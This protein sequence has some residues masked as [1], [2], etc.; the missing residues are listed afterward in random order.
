MQILDGKA[1]AEYFRSKISEKVKRICEL[2]FAPPRLAAFLIG[3]NKSSA[4]YIKMKEKACN[5]VGILTR[6]H[7]L[8]ADTP[9][10]KIIELIKTENADAQTSGI[11]VQVPL[12]KHYNEKKILSFID[13]QKDADCFLAENIGQMLIGNEKTV[14]PCTPLGI[15]KLLKYYGIDVA[16]KEVCIIGRSNIVG[17]PLI[18]L[19]LQQNATV[20]ICHSKTANLKDVTRRADI[21]VAAI[22]RAKM[23]D[24]SY[25]KHGAVVIDVGINRTEDENGK[26]IT[27]GDCDFESV[28]KVAGAITPVPKGI[29]PMTIAMVLYNTLYNYVIINNIDIKMDIEPKAGN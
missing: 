18:F 23:I 27:Y 2:G 13:T 19:M 21:L 24:A 17:K 22:G 5:E 9:E 8:E 15:M 3:D 7:I 29:G 1:C 6:T 20:T 26:S 12:P 4:M 25:V 11:L 14:I 16:S 28:S 10:E